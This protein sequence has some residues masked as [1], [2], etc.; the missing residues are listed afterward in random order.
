MGLHNEGSSIKT[1]DLGN[2]LMYSD[3]VRIWNSSHTIVPNRNDLIGN[4]SSTNAA[5]IVLLTLNS[6]YFYVFTQSGVGQLEI[7]LR[8]S[9]V[10][11]CLDNELGDIMPSQKNILL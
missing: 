7:G 2:L 11:M 10:D 4:I 1:N 5:F 9:V 8:H 6:R 3:G